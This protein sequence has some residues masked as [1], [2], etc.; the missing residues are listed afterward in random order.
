MGA[1]LCRGVQIRTPWTAG[2]V[3]GEAHHLKPILHGGTFFL[4]ELRVLVLGEH[5]SED[6]GD[7]IPERLSVLE[8]ITNVT[9]EFAAD[10]RMCMQS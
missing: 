8:R 6:D 1:A 10:G 2:A 7:A 3:P 9:F 5:K 4:G